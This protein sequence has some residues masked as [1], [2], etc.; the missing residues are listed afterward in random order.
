[1]REGKEMK[2]AEQNGKK[3]KD[4]YKILQT[5]G[6]GMRLAADTGYKTGYFM[7]KH[8]EVESLKKRVQKNHL[9]ILLTFA[10]ILLGGIGVA[11]LMDKSRK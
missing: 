1:M 4:A 2:T 6:Q 11:R 9:L 7:A 10:G 3:F 8:P 5:A